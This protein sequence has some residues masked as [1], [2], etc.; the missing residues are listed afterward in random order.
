MR[1]NLEQGS[2]AWHEAREKR[3]GSSEIFGLV[4]YYITEKELLNVGINPETFT[5]KPYVSAFELFYKFKAPGMYIGK[6]LRREYDIFGKRVEAMA[7]DYLR[8]EG[9]STIRRGGVYIDGDRIASLDIEATRKTTDIIQDING[10]YIDPVQYPE[11]IIEIKGKYEGMDPEKPIDWRHIFQVQYAMRLSGTKWCELFCASLIN[12]NMFERGYISALSKRRAIAYLNEQTEISR[13][14]MIYREDY[15][16]IMDLALER[17]FSDVLSNNPPAFDDVKNNEMVYNL[18]RQKSVLLGTTKDAFEDPSVQEYASLKKL[19]EDTEK[20]M[21]NIKKNI[22]R[23]M[24]L[25]G[26]T[27]AFSGNANLTIN[28]SS[29]RISIDKPKKLKAGK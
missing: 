18:V 20:T 25:N 12:D 15:Q 8:Q 26:K 24:L 19:A 5:E 2:D 6:V 28:K 23:R 3:I 9:I 1:V 11:Y 10:S 17:F 16:L 13:Y 29:L 22:T 4:K 7:R 14:Y 21:S 27:K